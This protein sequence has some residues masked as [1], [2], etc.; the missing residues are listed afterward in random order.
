M[1]LIITDT[2]A[3]AEVVAFMENEEDSLIVT[4]SD[5]ITNRIKNLHWTV[6]D[7]GVSSESTIV[8]KEIARKHIDES[9]PIDA[10]QIVEQMNDLRERHTFKEIK[11][12]KSWYRKHARKCQN[13]FKPHTKKKIE[14]YNQLC[15]LLQISEPT[16]NSSG[17]CATLKKGE[18][19]TKYR[20][21]RKV[22]TIP[23][24]HPETDVADDFYYFIDGMFG[25][26]EP[27]SVELLLETSDRNEA[28]CKIDELAEEMA[29]L[30]LDRRNMPD[31][32]QIEQ[33]DLRVQYA[34][35]QKDSSLEDR[36]TMVYFEHESNDPLR[37][38]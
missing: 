24:E 37:V 30:T 11:H 31:T 18:K 19:M 28:E 8:T 1:K 7:I 9:Y 32:V 36:L 13:A 29:S 38:D 25:E 14:A 35:K 26:F 22:Y 34:S 15:E 3:T 21:Y 5:N 23:V 12:S 6:L 2:E 17:V 10:E 16:E 33:Y 20:V 4:F 27:I